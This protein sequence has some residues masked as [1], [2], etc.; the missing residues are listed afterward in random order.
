LQDD[1]ILLAMFCEQV[2]R[3]MGLDNH[4]YLIT[5]WVMGL[6]AFLVNLVCVIRLVPHEEL[7]QIRW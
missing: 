3:E 4:G 2:E 6:V 5:S 7:Y 1:A